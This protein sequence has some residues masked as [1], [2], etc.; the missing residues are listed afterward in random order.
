[1]ALEPKLI[2][3]ATD[4]LTSLHMHEEQ[5]RARSV[6][7]IEAN[8]TLSDHWN[9]VAE[10]MNAIY[11]FAHDHGSERHCSISVSG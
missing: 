8:A 4:N 9:S 3:L 10:A 7:A 1:M 11:A 2:D 6:A 5:L